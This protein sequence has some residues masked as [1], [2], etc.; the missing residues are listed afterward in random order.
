MD[1]K[2]NYERIILIIL[3]FGTIIYAINRFTSDKN[4]SKIDQINT[5]IDSTLESSNEEIDK[6]KTRKKERVK[7]VKEK[8]EKQ[9]EE[10]RNIPKL[11]TS[12]RDS[13]WTILINSED[14]LPR[15]YWDILERK[16]RRKSSGSF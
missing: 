11:G 1:R 12:Q 6:Y 13:L 2:I 3:I 9:I 14:S 5:Q 16:T 15:R 8:N 7:K 10:I 4:S